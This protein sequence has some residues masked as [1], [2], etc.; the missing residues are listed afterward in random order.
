MT[1]KLIID[2]T[3][4]LPEEIL[5]KYNLDILP[6]RVYIDGKEYLD[7]VTIQLEHLY[8]LM[9]DG[10]HPKTSQVNPAHMK[11]IF[12]KHAKEGNECIY[13]CISGELSG[14]Y[15]TALLISKEVQETYPNF[16]I[17]IIDSKAGSTAIG[18]M[19]LQTLHQINDNWSFN[20][21]V[22]SLEFQTKHI[23][24]VFNVDDLNCL[25]RGGRLSKSAAFIGNMLN[26]KVILTLEN[27]AVKPVDKVRG[28]KKTLKKMVDIVEERIGDF[29]DQVIG[30]SHAEDY[31]AAIKLKEMLTERLGV[32]D[33][34][35]NL[36]GS[37][38]GSHLGIGGRGIFFLNKKP[39]NYI[40]LT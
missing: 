34:M 24:H 21:I 16:N 10:H 7:K 15:Q 37:S 39:K 9:R 22:E 35:I 3:C 14:T 25:H 6:L 5:E 26:V 27:G 32:K 20:D 31:E 30:I 12:E 33:Y 40:P 29:K 38:F 4:D 18:L 11:T 8:K 19:A 2:S 13:L 1:I 36:I 28:S 17:K 23:E